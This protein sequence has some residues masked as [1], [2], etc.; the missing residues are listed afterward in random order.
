MVGCTGHLAWPVWKAGNL[1]V[2]AHGHTRQIVGTLQGY[3]TVKM[4]ASEAGMRL[5]SPLVRAWWV[6]LLNTDM[7]LLG[8]KF[9]IWSLEKRTND[10]PVLIDAGT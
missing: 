2:V 1:K 9:G 10:G 3:N 7:G 8:G 5:R 6:P 4:H